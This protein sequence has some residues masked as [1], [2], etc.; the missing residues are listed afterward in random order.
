LPQLPIALNLFKHKTQYDTKLGSIENTLSEKINTI[1][2]KLLEFQNKVKSTYT[3]ISS[4]DSQ[5]HHSSISDMVANITLS[6]TS[7]QK[8]KEK[9]KFN[10]ILHNL[11]ESIANDSSV[12]KQDDIDRCS[13]LFSTYLN[14]TVSIK[15]AIC[16]EK[17]DSRPCHLL[18]LTLGNI[19]KNQHQKIYI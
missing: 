2:V 15:N 18:K 16:L 8:E 10:V 4:L 7:E 5:Q 1:E 17:R 14:A 19:K 3:S 9:R 13:S 12:R 11:S 6:L